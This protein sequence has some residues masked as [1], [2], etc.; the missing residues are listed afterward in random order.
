MPEPYTDT[1][2]T[3]AAGRAAAVAQLRQLADR[4]EGLPLFADQSCCSARSRGAASLPD[5]N[6]FRYDST[7]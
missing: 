6:R 4:L 3:V 2:A 5:C 7:P 1:L